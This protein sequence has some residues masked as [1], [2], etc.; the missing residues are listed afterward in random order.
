MLSTACGFAM[1]M[2]DAFAVGFIIGAV[3][4]ALVGMLSHRARTWQLLWC[5]EH[6]TCERIGDEFYY[7]V[8]EDR[9]VKMRIQ[10]MRRSDL[11]KNDD[12]GDAIEST[13]SEYSLQRLRELGGA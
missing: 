2:H 4:F 8:R 10:G 9:Y 5:A 3:V 7:I 13:A 1:S 12:H 11:T 6:E